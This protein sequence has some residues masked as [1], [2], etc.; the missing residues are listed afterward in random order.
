MHL[1]T[2]YAYEK[3]PNELKTINRYR[4]VNRNYQNICYEICVREM[5]HGNILDSDDIDT[6]NWH[7]WGN[8][9]RIVHF[10]GSDNYTENVIISCSCGI[11]NSSLYLCRHCFFVLNQLAYNG[12]II[13]NNSWF[14]KLIR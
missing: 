8:N 6:Y 9:I 12:D 4:F 5:F 11:L 3:M 10:S 1:C 13:L 14:E 2:P 7:T